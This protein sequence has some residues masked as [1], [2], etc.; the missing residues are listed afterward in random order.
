MTPPSARCVLDRPEHRMMRPRRRLDDSTLQL[1]IGPNFLS[2][3]YR[4]ALYN[5]VFCSFLYFDD[6]TLYFAQIARGSKVVS[7]VN[8][9]SANCNI[10]KAW[11]A[12]SFR[13]G[14]AGFVYTACLRGR[15]PCACWTCRATRAFF[16]Y[17]S[18]Q[19]YKRLHVR[20]QWFS[21]RFDTTRYIRS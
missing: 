7:P 10:H 16:R 6:V 12:I 9:H 1:Y 20:Y 19:R 21:I 18:I 17:D 5:P 2:S 14:G 15:V 11:T 13:V 8:E 4:N 3:K